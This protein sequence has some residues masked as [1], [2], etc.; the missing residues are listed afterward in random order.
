M[1][2]SVTATLSAW[3]FLETLQP[4]EIEGLQEHLHKS[5]F[6]DHQH[7]T[8]T[9]NFSEFTPIWEQ[10][11]YK[12][13]KDKMRQGKIM[14]QMY[15]FCFLFSEIEEDLRSIYNGEEIYNSNSKKCYGYTFTVDHKGRV[16]ID[17]LYVPMI[18]T[19]MLNLSKDKHSN[20]EET[21]FDN[22]EKFKY[23]CEA[24]LGGNPLDDIK[25]AKMDKLYTKYFQKYESINNGIFPHWVRIKYVKP[26]DLDNELNSFYL[27]DIETAKKQPS[28]ALKQ[29]ICGDAQ[30]KIHI[31]ENRKLIEHYLQPD[32]YPDGRWPSLVE[33]RLSLMQQVAVNHICGEAKT[34]SSVNGPPG[35]GKTTLLKDLFAHNVVERAKTFAKLNHP[36]DAF[37]PFK[38]HETD[39]YDTYFLNEV[40]TQFKMVVASSNNGAVENI[41]KDLPK[42]D[43]VIREEI[44]SKFP[45]YEQEYQKIA[46]ELGLFKNI[47]SDLIQEES[48]GLFSGV[49]GKKKNIDTV[50]KKLLVE[51]ESLNAILLNEAKQIDITQKW[52]EV[53]QSFNDT[54]HTI[55]TLKKEIKK[56]SE[57][58]KKALSSRSKIAYYH[59][60]LQLLNQKLLK[61]EDDDELETKISDLDKEINR[62][63]ARISDINEYEALSRM[64]ETFMTKLTQLFGG[65]SHKSE[66]KFQNHKRTLLEEK[67]NLEQD[68]QACIDKMSVIQVEKQN[69][70][71]D[72]KMYESKIESHQGIIENYDMFKSKHQGLM[73]SNDDFW[74]DTEESYA[75]RQESVLCTSDELQFQRGLLF[76]KAMVLHKYLLIGNAKSIQS[77]L[78]DFKNR[79]EYID[80]TLA[81]VENAWNVIHLIFPVISTTF[82]SFNSMYTKISKDFIDY[83]Y[84]DEAGQATPQAAVG[85]IQRSCKVVAV[86]DPIQIEPVVTLERHLYDLVRKAYNAPER[87]VNINASVQ[88]TSDY[89][90]PYGYW[91]GTGNEKQWIGIPLWVHRRCLNP[92]FSISNQ[93]AYDNKMVLPSYVKDNEKKGKTG[94]VEWIDVKGKA[95]NR[96]YVNEHGERIIELLKEDWS[97]SLNDEGIPPNVFVITPFTAIKRVLC[98]RVKIGLKNEMISDEDLSKW[99]DRSIGTVHTFQGKEADKVYFV[100]GTDDK[101][102]GAIQWSCAKPNLI[103][104]AVTRAKKTFIIIGD[105]ERISQLKYYDTIKHFESDAIK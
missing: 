17:T 62:V 105:K 45:Q 104:V 48:W 93:V 24:V 14:F 100:T 40:H 28:T 50:M 12:L 70:L 49:F 26:N 87:L 84:I 103:N 97:K 52:K 89:A 1:S 98:S 81:K 86:G 95:T 78:Y 65:Q 75:F 55:Q 63:N 35:T 32:F 47:A 88:S 61:F 37:T 72:I 79:F 44:E 39:Q 60:Q 76:L 23:E 46:Q 9:I 21:H 71:N 51:K 36:K 85:A 11:K 16:D 54:L 77:A 19:A 29:Y 15:R 102:N 22:F 66:S 68:K 38:I 6:E 5:L 74:R 42:I 69:T 83:L 8:K 91:K 58:Y 73:Y 25:L 59:T 67:I 43:E 92:M 41:S 96:Q 7:K 4:G 20:I 33:H 99:V 90:N 3:G 53:K 56:G 34:I 94:F 82:A 80:G 2:N 30:P 64:D 31:D 27:K 18:M 13:K 10:D 101:Q 57:N